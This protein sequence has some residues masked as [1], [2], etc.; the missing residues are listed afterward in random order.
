MPSIQATIQ[1]ARNLRRQG[2][3]GQAA[4]LL[5][6][7]IQTSPA[8]PEAHLELGLVLRQSGDAAGAEQAVR[9]ALAL[10]PENVDALEGLASLLTAR[11]EF[12]EAAAVFRRA[13]ELQPD[14]YNAWNGLGVALADVPDLRGAD[15]A[16]RRAIELAPRRPEAPSNYAMLL[17]RMGRI[18][19]S[20]EQS[21]LA[22]RI[23][24]RH[25][26]TQSQYCLA[27]NYWDRISAA[28]LFA[29]HRK[30]G[31]L[32]RQI[33]PAPPAFVHGP[34]PDRRLH[35]AFVSGDMRDH[36]VAFFAEP[37]LE[38]L[39]RERFSVTVFHT[40]VLRDATTERLRPLAQ[41]WHEV[42]TLGEGQ[43]FE[44]IRSAKPDVLID[45]SGHTAGG[46]LL[47]MAAK[48]APVTATYLGYPN[49]TGLR[50]IDWRIVDAWTDPPGAESLATE[51]LWR[52]EGCFLC[53]RPPRDAPPVEHRPGEK[54]PGAA[55]PVTFGSF[56]T[57]SKISDTTID[58]WRR[59][60]DACGGASPR[61]IL[62][63][64]GL[65]D[66]AT[67]SHLLDRFDR[68]G[69]GRERVELIGMTPG[70]ADHLA[71]Y[72]RVDVALD[73]FPYHGTTT[74]CE[75]LWMGVPVV[76]LAGDR[77]AARVGVSLLT[78]L[79]L[80]DMIAE[81]PD[82]YVAIAAGLA[83]DEH[84]RRAL[85]ATLRERMLHSPLC[86][87]RGFAERFGGALREMW[88]QWCRSR[89]R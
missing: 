82:Q 69:L 60:L 46:R 55:A 20:I 71:L 42:P 74:T 64:R 79:G 88:R 85:R 11:F 81:S 87:G 14:S 6:W 40:G 33:V 51:R 86:D 73:T 61:L 49:T 29:E 44:F 7:A 84:R 9:R 34:E 59:V 58:L 41:A 80:A 72:H 48:P 77:H 30:Y 50:S 38:H 35:V 54:Q 75:A 22:L 62:K 27:L 17:L 4:T 1:Q 56:N 43:L 12:S 76:T 2:Q 63:S 78:T 47:T 37:I 53:Y 3:L 21:K 23:N 8:T 39:D 25:P 89:A 57:I 52:L 31:D 67:R 68:L 65:E 15:E 24:P 5:R 26:P 10:A 32:V 13:L 28:D 16:F 19:E 70:K 36:S 45:L 18:A 83:R 66:E